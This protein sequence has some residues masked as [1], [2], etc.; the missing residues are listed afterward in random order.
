MQPVTQFGDDRD[1]LI[2]AAYHCLSHPE[3]GPA[4]I[5]AMLARAR[6]SARVF[7][8]YFA[9]KDE[10]FLAMLNRENDA[11]IARLA[12]IAGDATAKP[13]ERLEAWIIEMFELVANPDLARRATVLGTDD[14]RAARGYQEFR[15]QGDA[16]RQR[17]LQT[18]LHDGRQDGSFPLTDP[19]DDAAAID[20]LCAQALASRIAAGQGKQGLGVNFVVDFA[21]R[22][23]GVR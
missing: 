12:A 3:E 2:E 17:S 8:R 15:L 14:V 7:Y 23:L 19:A 10:L 16:A 6:V 18:I 21:M 20:A 9:S 4:S 1:C 13:A 5:A 11:L 22:S